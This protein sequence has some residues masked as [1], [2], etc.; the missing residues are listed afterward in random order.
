MCLTNSRQGV[1]NSP[2]I[3]KKGGMYVDVMTREKIKSNE[4]YL[5]KRNLSR[6]KGVE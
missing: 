6:E 5:D 2:I 4:S 3:A 1:Y